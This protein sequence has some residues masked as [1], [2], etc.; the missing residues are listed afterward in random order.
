VAVL[1]KTLEDADDLCCWKFGK[2]GVI[3]RRPY[4]MIVIMIIIIDNKIRE[5][6]KS[7][8]RFTKR[9]LVS[10]VNDD[11]SPLFAGLDQRRV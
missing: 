8:M 1:K 9:G 2:R 3:V 4:I 11:Q 7:I 6:R 10:F 5:H